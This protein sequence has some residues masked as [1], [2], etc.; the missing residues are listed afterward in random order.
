MLPARLSHAL[1]TR[2]PLSSRRWW[3]LALGLLLGGVLSGC[4]FQR[5]A[6]VAPIVS[7]EQF[8]AHLTLTAQAGKTLTHTIT[9]ETTETPLPTLENPFART[10]ITPRTST[11]TVTALATATITPT[12]TDSPTPTASPTVTQTPRPVIPPPVIRITRPAPLSKV[13]SPIQL[14]AIVPPGAG[15]ILRVD[16]LGEDGR[17]LARQVLTYHGI[18]LNLSIDLPFEIPGAAEAGR[19]QIFTADGHDRTMALSSV[20]LVLLSLG[21]AE[22]NPIGELRERL[23]LIEPKTDQLILG[24]SLS[25]LGKAMPGMDNPVMIELIAEN[26]AVLGRRLFNV[27]PEAG[28]VYG[29]FAGE[30][31]YQVSEAAPVLLTLYER[32]D[33]LPGYTHI[34]TLE[35]V[36]NP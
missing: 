18:N 10:A 1:I 31:D 30:I 34:T 27:Q 33:R 12:P 6:P 16:L 7:Q 24:G 13:T 11:A 5:P 25:I 21:Q 36:L 29:I 32:R 26:G 20:E 2:I 28:E 22:Y 23:F 14:R 19:L 15:G 4:T 8:Q 3:T 17:L 9:P 35:I